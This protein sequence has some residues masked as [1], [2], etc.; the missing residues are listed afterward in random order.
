MAIQI[1]QPGEKI[2][3]DRFHILKQL[4]KGGF[5]ITYLAE[6]TIKKQQIVIKTLNANQQGEADF[7]QK[8]ENFVKEGF[9]LR[10]F[11]HP[12]IVKVYE[13]IQI[14]DLWGLVME[15]IPGQDLADYIIANGRL[16]EAEALNYIDQIAQALD[17]V[18]QQKFFHRDVKPHNIMLRQDRG[19]A[20]LI[21]FGIAKEFVDLETIYLSNSLGTELY[22][23]IEQYEKR[24]Q[25]G[26][27]TDIYALAVTLYHLLTGAAPGGGSPLYTSKARKDAQDKGLG[28]NLDRHLWEKLAE[29]GISESTQAAIKAGMEIEPS[30]R[31]QT[32]TEFRELLKLNFSSQT[33]LSRL[34]KLDNQILVFDEGDLIEGELMEL[35]LMEVEGDSHWL[36]PS[37]TSE[38]VSSNQEKRSDSHKPVNKSVPLIAC[39]GITIKIRKYL[40]EI[41]PKHGYRS[42]Y[43]YGT[44]GWQIVHELIREKPDIILLRPMANDYRVCKEIRKNPELKNI[45]VVI[46]TAKD[47]AISHL[48]SKM[49]GA[50]DFLVESC[51]SKLLLK[52]IKDRISEYRFRTIQD[53]QASMIRRLS[54][55]SDKNKKLF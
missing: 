21:D 42:Y 36:Q 4:G 41:F 14:G 55:K 29:I 15:Y 31:P 50:N 16:G 18:H 7:A 30:Q 43:S 24:G 25:F 26:A 44:Y 11:N 53:A 22:K 38:S 6:D 23:P 2:K 51:E 19:E 52:T 28:T 39:V 40:E 35:D 17:C 33:N 1:W 46:L 8:Q 3:N 54:I 49:A 9:T 37:I 10:T 20:V 45:P 48:R 27:Y 32:M 47:G 5:G 13:P 34:E 12:H